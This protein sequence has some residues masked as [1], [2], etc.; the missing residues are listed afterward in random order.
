[1]KLGDTIVM[2]IDMNEDVR[3]FSFDSRTLFGLGEL[4]PGST[5]D[6]LEEEIGRGGIFGG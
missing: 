3:T 6:W 4:H 1:M 2:G 5:V